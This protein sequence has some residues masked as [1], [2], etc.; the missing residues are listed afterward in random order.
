MMNDIIPNHTPNDMLDMDLISNN[1]PLD[2]DEQKDDS[3]QL[4]EK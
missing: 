1:T 2:F 3:K 4:C